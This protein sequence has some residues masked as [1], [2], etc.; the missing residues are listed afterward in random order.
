M[1]I[2]V[3]FS[4][5]GSPTILNLSGSRMVLN[6]TNEDLKPEPAVRYGEPALFFNAYTAG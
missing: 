2:S 4:Y 6:L 3:I 1:V 5:I